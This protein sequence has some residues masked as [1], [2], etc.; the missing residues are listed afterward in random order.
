M[1]HKTKGA[2]TDE[3]ANAR[4]KAR[5]P[6]CHGSFKA[7][8]TW[9]RSRTILPM[10]SKAF[11]TGS[12]ALSKRTA[13]NDWHWTKSRLRSSVDSGEWM[14]DL[15]EHA[16]TQ[17]AVGH[18][19]HYPRSAGYK[20]QDTSKKAA[21][22]IDAA[23]L[24]GKCLRALDVLHIAT[25]DCVADYLD[26]SVLSIRPRFT[27]LL[28]LGMIEDSGQRHMNISGRSAKAWRRI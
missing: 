28:A 7:K 8:T 20:D 22:T 21:K 12:T 6:R 25:A 3:R 5:S 10:Q 9:Q 24:R 4:C 17:A 16:Q 13:G 26:E 23:G 19:A 1:Q 14:M 27:E 18:H 2:K 15:F 11:A